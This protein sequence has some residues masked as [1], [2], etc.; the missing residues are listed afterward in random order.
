[1]R[2]EI[3]RLLSSPH[4]YSVRDGH[5][6]SADKYFHL[7]PTVRHIKGTAKMAF[8]Q[9]LSFNESKSSDCTISAHAHDLLNSKF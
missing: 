4:V 8:W 7:A 1:M 5:R 2:N 6:N 3:S 9:L